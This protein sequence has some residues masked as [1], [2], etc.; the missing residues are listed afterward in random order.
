[1][2][3]RE[4]DAGERA[5]FFALPGSVDCQL[6]SAEMQHRFT[7]RVPCYIGKGLQGAEHRGR[8]GIKRCR[9][10]SFVVQR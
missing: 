2:G 9:S 3:E 5:P 6:V 1:M 7:T 8:C 4:G 10:F